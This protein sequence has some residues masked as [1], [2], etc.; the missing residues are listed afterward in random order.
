MAE[1]G[2][3]TPSWPKPWGRDAGALELAVIDDEFRS[4]KELH[5]LLRDRGEAIG[6]ATVYRTL[7]ALAQAGEVDVLLRDDGRFKGSA[8]CNENPDSRV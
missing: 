4:A 3:L 7:A 8:A 1:A 2:Y 5:A 6:L